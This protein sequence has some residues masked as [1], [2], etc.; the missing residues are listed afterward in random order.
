M[1][2]T[3]LELC[4]SYE[5]H[6]VPL[7]INKVHNQS[8]TTEKWLADVGKITYISSLLRT[9]WQMPHKEIWH[10]LPVH[11]NM[12]LDSGPQPKSSGH[13]FSLKVVWLEKRHA[14]YIYYLHS[15]RDFRARRPALSST[16][17]HDDI[18]GLLYAHHLDS[19]APQFTQ[20]GNINQVL[21]VLPRVGQIRVQASL[22]SLPLFPPTIWTQVK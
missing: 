6:P 12:T 2:P 5:R 16:E 1:C 17:A 18:P 3:Q 4:L 19:S 11:Q 13:G 7:G 22:S 20:P 10:S 9:I 8:F 21:Q 14:P 15:C